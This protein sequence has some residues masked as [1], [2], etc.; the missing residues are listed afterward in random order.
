MYNPE[1]PSVQ[2]VACAYWV[3]GLQT[4]VSAVGISK[5]L[6]RSLYLLF[7]FAFQKVLT[8]WHYFYPM[9]NLK[10]S[11]ISLINK[12]KLFLCSNNFCALITE[13]FLSLLNVGFG[14]VYNRLIYLQQECISEEQEWVR[15]MPYRW[16]TGFKGDW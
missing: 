4:Y 10:I 14:T 9:I 12:W 15:E 2:I 11:H 13:A 3:L 8:L 7:H 6:L 5:I 16:S 1:Y